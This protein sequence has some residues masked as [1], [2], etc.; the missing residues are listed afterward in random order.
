MTSEERRTYGLDYRS[1]LF[2]PLI[3]QNSLPSSMSSPSA[4]FDQSIFS[5]KLTDPFSDRKTQSISSHLLRCTPPQ[6]RLAQNRPGVRYRPQIVGIFKLS[7]HIS[8]N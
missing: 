4:R 8:G 2:F 1:P 3:I 6:N 5:K 7:I